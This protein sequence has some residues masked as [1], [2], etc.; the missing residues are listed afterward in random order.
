MFSQLR[1]L[2]PTNGENKVQYTCWC[3]AGTTIYCQKLE[4]LADLFYE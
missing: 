1:I 4:Y 3:N 2:Q